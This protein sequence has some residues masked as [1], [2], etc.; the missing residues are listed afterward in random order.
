MTTEYSIILVALVLIS[1]FGFIISPKIGLCMAVGIAGLCSLGSFLLS[2]FDGQ[3]NH[4]MLNS[5]LLF[6]I[7]LHL[8]T[9]ED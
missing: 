7:A 8:I 1:S 5:A 4:T 2:M 9:R 6:S 3:P